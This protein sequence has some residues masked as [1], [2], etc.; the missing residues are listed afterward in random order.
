MTFPTWCK[1]RS[2][3]YSN[4][5]VAERAVEY[6]V[7]V[8]RNVQTV[9]VRIVTHA[10]VPV[11]QTEEKL[12]VSHKAIV[13]N[14]FE[15][16]DRLTNGLNDLKSKKLRVIDLSYNSYTYDAHNNKK[17]VDQDGDEYDRYEMEDKIMNEITRLNK[18]T[19]TQFKERYM[20]TLGELSAGHRVYDIMVVAVRTELSDLIIND[21]TNFPYAIDLLIKTQCSNAEKE[22]LSL[23]A[24]MSDSEAVEVVT[25]FP[26][27]SGHH[28]VM[29]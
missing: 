17:F 19:N 20:R 25:A 23:T 28:L 12:L 2:P 27:G 18:E 11:K 7:E 29:Q 8:Q 4:K 5:A 15:E 13:K 24:D 21:H 3:K 26:L 14:A 22:I 6:T 9:G 10:V 1:K 16:I